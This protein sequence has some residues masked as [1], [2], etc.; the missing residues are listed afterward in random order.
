MMDI[1][2]THVLDMKEYKNFFTPH[3]EEGW[4][5]VGGGYHAVHKRNIHSN[6]FT[7]TLYLHQMQNVQ[8]LSS[9]ILCGCKSSFKCV[10]LYLL[11]SLF[12]LT[13]FTYP[14]SPFCRVQLV[15][16]DFNGLL[17]NDS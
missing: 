7:N 9:Q 17:L 16:A 13:A 5:R 14:Y 1:H 6:K 12:K 3:L 2:A 15:S 8:Y 4:G 10:F 11:E